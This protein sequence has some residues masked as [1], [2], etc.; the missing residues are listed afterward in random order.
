MKIQTTNIYY[1]PTLYSP[2]KKNG[3]NISFSSTEASD[4][5]RNAKIEQN[6]AREQLKRNRFI[7]YIGALSLV[8]S[9]AAGAV[10]S[11]LSPQKPNAS[12]FETPPASVGSPFD[13][14]NDND[15]LGVLTEGNQAPTVTSPMEDTTVPPQTEI[16]T[17]PE[18]TIPETTVPVT[19][20]TIPET[21]IQETEPESTETTETNGDSI[22]P[23]IQKI[24][25]ENPNVEAQY[26][27]IVESLDTFSKHL[28]EDGITAIT[29][30]IEKNGNGVVEPIDVLKILFIESS[31]RIYRND[32]SYL[33]NGVGAMGPFQIKKVVEKDINRIYGGDSDGKKVNISNAYGNL[34]AFVLWWR[35]INEE[36]LDDVKLPSS[37]PEHKN[38]KSIAAWL[39]NQG[40]WSES[41]SSEARSYIKTFD[42]LSILDEYPEV[43]DYILNG[44]E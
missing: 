2:L 5:Y 43:V 33:V 19:E 41:V 26:N 15:V 21:T 38:E 31:G 20:E 29:R 12:D 40:A 4:L 16:E 32:G 13:N 30:S 42:E 34:D 22:P 17:V 3:A 14:N 25:D 36:R 9:G 39:Y 35:F 8:V 18:T 28:G 1:K 10:I 44:G 37:F 24:F 6:K 23:K 27:K 7:A 11:F